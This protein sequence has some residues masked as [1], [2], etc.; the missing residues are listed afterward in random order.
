[1]YIYHEIHNKTLNLHFFVSQ[2]QEKDTSL[3]TIFIY[4]NKCIFIYIYLERLEEEGALFDATYKY[5][6]IH[7]YTNTYHKY[8]CIYMHV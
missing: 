4:M 6:Y 8:M 7:L 1:M 2:D 3:Q 5:R